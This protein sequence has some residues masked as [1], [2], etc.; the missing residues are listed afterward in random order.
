VNR[1]VI[2]ALAGPGLPLIIDTS[3]GGPTDRFWD[4]GDG[5]TSTEQ[6]PA[7]TYIAPGTY[8]VNLTATNA[9]GS[10]TA[11]KSDYIR[12]VTPHLSQTSLQT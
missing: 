11:T 3:A 10:S 12:V 4:L 8:T 2:A 7:H 1:I 6:N 9:D 5:A